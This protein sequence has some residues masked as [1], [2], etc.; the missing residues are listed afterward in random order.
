MPGRA[1]PWVIGAVVIAVALLAL[2]DGGSTSPAIGRGRRAPDFE[3][4]RLGGEASVRLSALRGSV[5][6]V[7]FWATWCKP[8]EDEMPAMERLYRALRPDGFELLAVSVDDEAEAVAEFQQRLGLSFPILLDP[9]KDV[10]SGLYHTFR[11]PESL[12]IGRDGVV[13]ERYIGP[14]DWD[15]DAY[16][17]RIRRLLAVGA[18]G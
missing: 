3:L 7:N 1:G 12:L 8:C 11:F 9:R 16:S 10:A 14:K 4:P 5:V 6:L 15:A 18:A 2:L 13:V 17:E